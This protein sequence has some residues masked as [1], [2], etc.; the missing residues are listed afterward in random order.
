[1]FKILKKW[2]QGKN[3]TKQAGRK[4][5]L[6]RAGRFVSPAPKTIANRRQAARPDPDVSLVDEDFD[7]TVEDA[8]P[9]KNVL[10]R[11]KYVR[12]ETGTYET[13]TILDDSLVDSGEETGIDPYNTGD[14][15]RSRNWDKRFRN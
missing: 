2:F 13:L 14:F 5:D 3:R 6:R 7:G 9:G 8:G 4:P 15:D 10:I 12:E 11:N 1:M